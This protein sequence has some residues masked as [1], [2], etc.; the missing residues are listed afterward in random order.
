MHPATPI[1][2]LVGP[3]GPSALRKQRHTLFPQLLSVA[4]RHLPLPGRRPASALPRDSLSP[5]P[6]LAQPNG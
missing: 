5:L 3:R 1:A 6:S 2:H 4:A